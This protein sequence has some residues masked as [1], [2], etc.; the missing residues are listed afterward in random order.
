MNTNG[1]EHVPAVLR[2]LKNWVCWREELRDGE[3]TKVPYSP[4]TGAR[5][6][7]NDPATWSTWDEA[8]RTADKY[9]GV[10]FMMNGSPF[11]GIDFDS[12]LQNGKPEPIIP[13]ILR[14]LGEP[15]TEITPSGEGLRAFVRFT[16]KLP[17]SNRK[18]LE[19]R[20]GKKYGAELYGGSDP[21]RYFTVT[22]RKFSGNGVSVPRDMDLAYLLLGNIRD[23]KFKRLFLGDTSDYGNDQS[24]ADLALCSMLARGVGKNPQLIDRFFRAS[25]LMRE[26]WDGRRG[27]TTYGMQTIAKALGTETEVD[28]QDDRKTED[29]D[30]VPAQRSPF[31]VDIANAERFATEH[32]GKLVYVV[33]R[34]IRCAFNGYVWRLN[35]K[36]A[37][38]RFAKETIRGMYAEASGA[39]ETARVELA[40]HAIR[41]ETRVAQMLEC[42]QSDL[43][44]ER[45]KFRETFDLDPLLLNCANGILNLSTGRIE[46]HRASAMLTKITNIRY[47]PDAQCPQFERFLAHTFADNQALIAYV[48]NLMGYCLSG[49]TKEHAFWMFYGPTQTSKSTFVKVQRGLAGE[50]G[51]T[52][53]A[54]AIVADRGKNQDYALAELASVRLATTVELSSDRRFDDAI[55]KQL[56]GQDA[57]K[58]CKKYENFFEFPSTAKLVIATNHR[59]AIRE[60]D[61]AIWSRVKSI[62]FLVPVAPADQIDGY[63]EKLLEREGP[64]ILALA[65]RAFQNWEKNGLQEPA[66]VRAAVS[67]YRDE[68]DI[69]RNFVLDRCEEHAEMRERFAT[70]Y[71]LYCED[72][73]AAGVRPISRIK[74]GEELD[75]LGHPDLRSN[76]VHYRLGLRTV[77][78]VSDSRS[79]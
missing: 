51:A 45:W 70:L 64:G 74:F 60:T 29:L 79:F 1:L 57:I 18:F 50:Y 15:Y 56:T 41:S 48:K 20:N 33:D 46:S 28:A 19:K 69:V 30:R 26:K 13:V 52:L 7:S 34:K 49:L 61:D 73:K 44:I 9:N 62:P 12:V 58:A 72:A 40:K 67:Q 77:S 43:R 6:K 39:D 23:E 25:G 10:G 47:E 17:G 75:R 71:A 36:G 78:E 4:K 11:T 3:R 65:V 32:A 54:N 68:Q 53:P 27:A 5:A 55:L 8:R 63:A 31:K 24:R 16:G 38:E 35:D 21:G 66:E 37:W 42:A 2:E 22:G 14:E 59:P 76:G